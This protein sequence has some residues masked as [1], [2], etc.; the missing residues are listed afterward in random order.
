MK[1]IVI[2]TGAGISAESGIKTFRDS[3][4]LWNNHSIYE[5]A[6]PEAWAANKQLV[7]DFY[8]SRRQELANVEPNK[9]HLGL[10]D[11]EQKFETVIITQNVD[12]LHERAGSKNVL[13]LHG[14]LTQARGE[15]SL[16]P[17]IE[18]GYKD[19][20]LGDKTENGAQIRPHIVWFG[21]DVPMIEQAAEICYD[22]NIFLVIGTSMQVY[23]ASGLINVLPP[24]CE[25]YL[26]D[27]KADEIET[28]GNVT[29]IKEKAGTAVPALVKTLMKRRS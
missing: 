3:D 21:E 5:V 17:I 2:L 22:A 6:T 13:H 10:V 14:Q 19:I 7:L 4:G 18:I 28:F 27:P 11:L 20:K 23:P 1:K 8:N 24:N 16:S 15:Y 12:N 25:I 26:I 29:V 9:G